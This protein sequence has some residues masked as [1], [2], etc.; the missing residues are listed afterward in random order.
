MGRPQVQ[1]ALKQQGS[2]DN[3]M[4]QSHGSKQRAQQHQLPNRER[5][6][7]DLSDS[8]AVSG[9]SREGA[10]RWQSE[11]GGSNEATNEEGASSTQDLQDFF[12]RRALEPGAPSFAMDLANAIAA[13]DATDVLEEE[14]PFSL[15][16]ERASCLS[17]CCTCCHQTHHLHKCNC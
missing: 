1:Y 9:R 11:N 8:A 5:P 7:Q 2:S 6:E 14:Q 17:P 13:V 12:T 4:P 10:N 3:F 15:V 16:T